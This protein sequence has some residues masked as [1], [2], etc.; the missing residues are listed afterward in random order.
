[1]KTDSVYKI[2]DGISFEE[3]GIVTTVVIEIGLAND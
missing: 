2:E 3:E 1:M